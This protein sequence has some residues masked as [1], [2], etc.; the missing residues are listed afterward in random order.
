VVTHFHYDSNFP[1]RLL[2]SFQWVMP[3]LVRGAQYGME[4][5]F[6]QWPGV[7]QVRKGV[8]AC[9]VI[10]FCAIIHSY[11]AIHIERDNMHCHG[12]TC[13]GSFDT[14]LTLAESQK[15]QFLYD[16]QLLSL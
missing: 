1:A 6:H 8:H 15:L 9:M 10:Y 13:T 12:I 11:C 14:S 5:R 3:G 16:Y 2:H 7:E 4:M